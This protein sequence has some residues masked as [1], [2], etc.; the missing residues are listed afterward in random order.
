MTPSFMKPLMYFPKGKGRK[1]CGI[2]NITN[3]VDFYLSASAYIILSYFITFLFYPVLFVLFHL[4]HYQNNNF[5][6]ACFPPRPLTICANLDLRAYDANKIHGYVMFIF[7]TSEFIYRWFLLCVM[8]L[9]M[10]STACCWWYILI[11]YI[12]ANPMQKS[13]P[14]VFI[15]CVK[16]IIK[17]RPVLL[18]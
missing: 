15:N 5:M 10:P 11:I 7:L 8:L 16:S 18:W 12:H 2:S 1:L 6:S 4:Q 13:D 14:Y 3:R 9:C 17:I